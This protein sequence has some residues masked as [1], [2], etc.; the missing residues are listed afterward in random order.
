[1]NSKDKTTL[2]ETLKDKFKG[3]SISIEK[4]GESGKYILFVVE[5]LTGKIGFHNEADTMD[6][7]YKESFKILNNFIF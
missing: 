3:H 5:S 7:L 1:M 6:S 4:H 2:V